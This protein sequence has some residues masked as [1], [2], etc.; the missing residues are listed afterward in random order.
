MFLAQK[1]LSPMSATRNWQTR[2]RNR[3][4][5]PWENAEKSHVSRGRF[6]EKSENPEKSAAVK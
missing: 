5:R 2:G 6:D 4:K 1:L 3:E